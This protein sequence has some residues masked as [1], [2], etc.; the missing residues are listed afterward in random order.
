MKTKACRR[1][2]IKGRNIQHKSIYKFALVNFFLQLEIKKLDH[3]WSF[4]HKHFLLTISFE[5][6]ISTSQ[7]SVQDEF[8]ND[9]QDQSRTINDQLLW[10]MT[11][12]DQFLAIKYNNIERSLWAQRSSTI[13]RTTLPW[14]S[15][16]IQISWECSTSA[17][18]KLKSF[19]ILNQWNEKV[20]SNVS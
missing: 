9:Q 12:C 2:I 14:S 3:N 5:L 4:N 18:I 19:H 7:L 15:S 11:L 20:F 8:T 1:S 10:K 16:P 13:P 6:T 17:E